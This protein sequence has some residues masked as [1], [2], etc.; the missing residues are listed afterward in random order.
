MGSGPGW[1]PHGELWAWGNAVLLPTE[2]TFVG[3][4]AI[5]DT[6]NPHDDKVYVFF[7]ETALEGGQWERRHI[8]AR[9]ARVCKVSA[10]SGG[11]LAS[12]AAV[13]TPAVGLDLVVSPGL[14]SLQI[15]SEWDHSPHLFQCSAAEP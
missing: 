9:V 11:R 8:H 6:H 10:Q 5:P 12:P 15:P 14:C 4:F 7:R 1:Q 13:P 2:P 3:A